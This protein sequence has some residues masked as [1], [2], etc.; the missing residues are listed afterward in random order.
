MTLPKQLRSGTS[1]W[2][3]QLLRRRGVG[4]F[5]TEHCRWRLHRHHQCGGRRQLCDWWLQRHDQH[6]VRES[7]WWTNGVEPELWWIHHTIANLGPNV[8]G[9]TI[10]LRFRMC[11]DS[12]VSGTGWRVDNVVVTGGPCGPTPTPCVGCTP[13][14][15]PVVTP[16][17]TPRRT[18]AN[19]LLWI[20]LGRVH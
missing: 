15:T 14:P 5:V 4:S 9:Q 11:S 17:P 13:T 8:V 16:T 10:K 18:N 19:T 1:W 7:D 20:D 12:S 6:G 2:W 3:S